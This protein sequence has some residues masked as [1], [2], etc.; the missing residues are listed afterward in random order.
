VEG[1]KSSTGLLLTIREVTRKGKLGGGKEE[2]KEGASG[3]FL[4]DRPAKEESG[5][6]IGEEEG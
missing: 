1:G 4:V 2:E 5:E 6:G 3:L